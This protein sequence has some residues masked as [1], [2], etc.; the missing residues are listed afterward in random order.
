MD[1]V[2]VADYE[3]GPA[4]GLGY[5]EYATPSW[6]RCALPAVPVL[7]GCDGKADMVETG[8]ILVEGSAGKALVLIDADHQIGGLMWLRAITMRPV[9]SARSN[10]CRARSYHAALAVDVGHRQV[11]VADAA[12]WRCSHG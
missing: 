9:H 8:P 1:V 3:R 12:K 10:R 5:R 2:R 6:I 7:A 11:D 4:L